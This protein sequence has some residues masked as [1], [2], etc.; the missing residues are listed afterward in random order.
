MVPTLW[1]SRWHVALPVACSPLSCLSIVVVASESFGAKCSII[2]NLCYAHLL[3]RPINPCQPQ[4]HMEADDCTLSINSVEF[5]S[6]ILRAL[7][8]VYSED[9]NGVSGSQFTDGPSHIRVSDKRSCNNIGKITQWLSVI[10]NT[11]NFYR[12]FKNINSRVIYLT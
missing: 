5:L 7:P 4:G 2:F 11:S 8:E 6:L 9:S 3:P 1:E 10:N 12:P